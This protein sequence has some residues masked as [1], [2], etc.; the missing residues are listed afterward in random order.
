VLDVMERLREHTT[1]FY[2]TH[3]L[4]DVQRVSDYVAILNNGELVANA[5]TDELLAGKEDAVYT[6]TTKGDTGSTFAQLSAQSWVSK[7]ELI[8]HNGQTQWYVRVNN[9]EIAEGQLLRQFLAD[10][11]MVVTEFGRKKYN[12]E[13]VFMSIVAGDDDA[14][15]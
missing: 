8:P 13:E 3:I 14:E 5:T 1:I 4:D 2:S 10:E 7:V 9:E 15:Q 12:L 11:Q 6:L